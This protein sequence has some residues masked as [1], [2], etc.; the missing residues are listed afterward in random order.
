MNSARSLPLPD[1]LLRS[2][3]PAGP[4]LGIDTGTPIAH[5]G[6]VRD[7]RILASAAHPARSHGADLPDLTASLLASAR[8]SFKDLTAI[9]VGLGPGSFTGLRV[10]LSYAK[11]LA[12]GARLK[13]VGIP[14]LDAIALAAAAKI[15]RHPGLTICPLIDARKGEVYTSLY[16]VTDDAL[17]RKTDDLIVAFELLPRRL[18]GKVVFAG[19]AKAEE[20]CA[21][22]RSGG[23]DCEVIGGAHLQLAGGFIAA[24]GAARVALND[25][26]P[27]M[28][29]EPRYVRSPDATV[30]HSALKPGEA[31]HG[32]T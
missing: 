1:A 15:H 5:L 18:E 30:K 20:A 23:G 17:E 13:L 24:M 11:G 10:G 8:L 25:V 29:L 32:T 28:G 3:A 12:L 26:D 14:S 2:G 4:V 27:I 31:I 7:G 6:L 19:E 9:A 22:F 21:L 16:R